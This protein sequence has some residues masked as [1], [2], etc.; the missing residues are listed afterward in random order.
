MITFSVITLASIVIIL[1]TFYFFLFPFY[2]LKETV[3]FS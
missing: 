3:P 2:F 1:F